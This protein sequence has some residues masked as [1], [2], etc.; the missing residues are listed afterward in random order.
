M[1]LHEVNQHP[2]LWHDEESVA[3]D[4]MKK[5]DE[6]VAV[7]RLLSEKTSSVK[8]DLALDSE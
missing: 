7:L 8:I 4:A 1:Q 5:L 6:V 2:E 3:K